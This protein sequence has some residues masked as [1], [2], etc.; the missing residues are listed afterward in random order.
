MELGLDLSVP[1]GGGFGADGL[2]CAIV[3][4]FGAGDRLDAARVWASLGTRA[5]WFVPEDN[6]GYR[7][8]RPH[9]EWSAGALSLENYGVVEALAPQLGCSVRVLGAPSPAIAAVALRDALRSGD[10]VVVATRE[11]LDGSPDAPV[12]ERALLARQLRWGAGEAA[13]AGGGADRT[14][15]LLLDADRELPITTLF[16]VGPSF[17][18]AP[19]GRRRVLQQDALRYASQHTSSALGK[20]LSFAEELYYA[21]GARALRAA[22]AALRAG[23]AARQ[24]GW[25]GYWG[26]W[27]ADLRAA[28]V[29][30]SVT[31]AAWAHDATVAPA[32]ADWG[33][34]GA[35]AADAASVATDPALVSPTEAAAEALERLAAADLRVAEQLRV[36]VPL[37]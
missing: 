23:A 29:S 21:S 34:V 35:A 20:E 36:A 24:P 4:A 16:V 13:G 22:A 32:D 7:D 26:R 30:L 33:A 3:E 15:P 1:G 37:G 2:L 31:A 5:Y 11:P 14:L 12:V 18:D 10:A 19:P 27:V 6:Y 25:D 28:R 9:V 8:E 17:E